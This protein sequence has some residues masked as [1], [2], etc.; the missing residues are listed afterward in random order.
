MFNF[1]LMT[2]N[3]LSV[4]KQQ[5]KSKIT[6]LNKKI[7][8]RKKYL[9]SV[10]NPK[11]TYVPDETLEQW[12]KEIAELAEE[13]NRL[14]EYNKAYNA[15]IQ[16]E[17]IRSQLELRKAQDEA[18]K[19]DKYRERLADER[20][21]KGERVWMGSEFRKLRPAEKRLI[22]LMAREIGQQRFQ[23]LRRIAFYDEKHH[24]NIY[25]TGSNVFNGGEGE[26][27]PESKTETNV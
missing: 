12:K 19:Y 2:K 4:Y 21:P 16:A 1:E 20:R 17:E 26:Y 5:L 9:K 15:R 13:S 11:L 7:S 23:E 8:E 3:Q 24:K 25:Y 27:E 18:L 14:K 6:K 10:R 22:M